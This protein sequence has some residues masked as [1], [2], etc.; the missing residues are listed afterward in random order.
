M[1][2]VLRFVSPVVSPGCIKMGK[3]LITRDD[4][5]PYSRYSDTI[6]LRIADDIIEF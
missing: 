2:T 5:N 1:L 3:L 6:S 4:C